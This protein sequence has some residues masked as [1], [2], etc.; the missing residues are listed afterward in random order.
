MFLWGKTGFNAIAYVDQTLPITDSRCRQTF[1]DG[2]R[3]AGVPEC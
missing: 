3:R 2:L 1:L